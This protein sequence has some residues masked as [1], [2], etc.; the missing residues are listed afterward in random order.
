[1]SSIDGSYAIE[2]RRQHGTFP[3][4]RRELVSVERGDDLP[5]PVE[6]GQP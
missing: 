5:Q 4:T 1:M 2:P 3:R 6:P